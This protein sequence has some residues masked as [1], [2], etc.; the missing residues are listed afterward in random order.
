MNISD[1]CGSLHLRENIVEAHVDLAT[2]GLPCLPDVGRMRLN[3]LYPHYEAHTHLGMIEVLYCERGDR[4]AVTAQGRKIAFRAGDV[5]V[6]QPHLRHSISHHPKGLVVSGYRFRLPNRGETILGLSR[7]ETAALVRAMR[8]L[9]KFFRAS[10]RLRD[11]LQRVFDLSR[12]KRRK[13]LVAVKMHAAALDLLIA[14]IEA[15]SLQQGERT[16]SSIDN[17][18]AQMNAHP[19]FDYRLETIAAQ[20]RRSV[21]NLTA[22]FKLNTGTT[23]YAYL[24]GR[25]IDKAMA[26]L[27]EG[28]TNAREVARLC[29][30]SSYRHFSAQFK[31]HAGYSPRTWLANTASRR[32]LSG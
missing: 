12:L 29:G 13:P 30:Y 8:K 7:T 5:F 9:P 10:D 16:V 28:K 17:L 32:V 27:K 31:T 22:Q 18:I 24:L 4:A 11:A 21:T 15:P 19:E 6:A 14:T 20:V 23:P 1:T 3:A 26:L 25:R 2:Y